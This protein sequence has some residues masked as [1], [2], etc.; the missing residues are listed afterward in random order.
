MT[1]MTQATPIGQVSVCSTVGD[2]DDVVCFGGDGAAQ[3]GVGAAL[4]DALAERVTGD[5]SV[6]EAL[7]L[8]PCEGTGV[9]GWVTPRLG[10]VLVT[11]PVLRSEL[12]TSG[13]RAS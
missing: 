2:G 11:T 1:V 4:A 8:G 10:L 13:C 12:P 5:D 3:P 6:V 9:G 7:A